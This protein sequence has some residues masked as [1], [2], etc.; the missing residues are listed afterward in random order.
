MWEILKNFFTDCKECDILFII[1]HCIQYDRKQ[2]AYNA[3]VLTLKNKLR[4]IYV[5]SNIA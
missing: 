4:Y 1:V 5:V 2:V 3:W